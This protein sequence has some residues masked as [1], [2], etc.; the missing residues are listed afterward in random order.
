MFDRL[1]E[2]EVADR[3]YYYYFFFTKLLIFIFFSF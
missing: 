2:H 3:D 1:A